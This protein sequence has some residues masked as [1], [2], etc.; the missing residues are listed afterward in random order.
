[1]LQNKPV[2][3]VP[4]AHRSTPDDFLMTQASDHKPST[5]NENRR[6]RSNIVMRNQGKVITDHFAT[7][8][9]TPNKGMSG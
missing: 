5:A 9:H 8:V 1:M 2:H 3:V 4:S 7:H 6:S